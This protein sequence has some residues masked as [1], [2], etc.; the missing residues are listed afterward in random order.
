MA[1]YT[2][3]QQ[4]AQRL[5]QDFLRYKKIRLHLAQRRRARQTKQ[6]INN[7][8][9]E[10]TLSES[11]SESP[12][13]TSTTDSTSQV[14]KSDK[15][16]S[17]YFSDTSECTTFSDHE[18]TD[19][20]ADADS[21]FSEDSSVSS[22]DSDEETDGE[23]VTTHH[24][25]QVA[26]HVRHTLQDIFARRYDADISAVKQESPSE[27]VHESPSL[28]SSIVFEREPTSAHEPACALKWKESSLFMIH[29]NTTEKF[30]EMVDA[31]QS[32]GDYMVCQI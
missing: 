3:C 27:S 16:S 11:S 24:Q 29:H 20:D 12:T 5:L 15:S 17:S 2:P 10:S 22:F 23:P 13:T 1:R 7:F 31:I 21:E 8:V 26:H 9:T 28:T 18:S 32:K 14:S 19:S 30:I 25:G 6:Q 4:C